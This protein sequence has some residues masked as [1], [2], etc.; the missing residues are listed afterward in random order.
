MSTMSNLSD[1]RLAANRANALKSTGPRS[2]DGK[3]VS[4]LNGLIHGLRASIV[5]LP[6]ENADDFEVIRTDLIDEFQPQT[7]TEQR[8]IDT[9]A[10]SHWAVDRARKQEI[11]VLTRKWEDAAEQFDY[12][13]TQ[14]Y[15]PIFVPHV[16]AATDTPEKR[17]LLI[18]KWRSIREDVVDFHWDGNAIDEAFSILGLNPGDLVTGDS[19]LVEEL[20]L[21]WTSLFFTC[22]DL[23]NRHRVGDAIYRASSKRGIALEEEISRLMP[24]VPTAEAGQARILQMIDEQIAK[25][26]TTVDPAREDPKYSPE[27]LAAREAA[28]TL[29]MFDGSREG[30]LRLRYITA[31]ENTYSR[32]LRNLL[33]V[34][35]ARLKECVAP[36]PALPTEPKPMAPPEPSPPTEPKPEESAQVEKRLVRLDES[37]VLAPA[38]PI[39]PPHPHSRT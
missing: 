25:L 2:P 24:K 30:A 36:A 26:E 6:G 8:L 13:Q 15:R 21:A 18:A 29:A 23:P 35:K 1:A 9:M 4:S 12:D 27:Y 33:A 22:G 16:P 20:T 37:P 32:A 17:A 5:V 39:N 3:A 7:P 28:C 31:H 14:P 38:R 34:R 19:P 10:A 11:A